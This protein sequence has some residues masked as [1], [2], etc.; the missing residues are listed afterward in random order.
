MESISTFRTWAE[1]TMC[2]FCNQGVQQCEEI[3]CSTCNKIAHQSCTGSNMPIRGHVLWNC[4]ECGPHSMKT[5]TALVLELK[6]CHFPELEEIPAQISALKQEIKML[7]PNHSAVLQREIHKMKKF[8][9]L[10]SASPEVE[11][12]IWED[13]TK[14]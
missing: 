10:R 7:K 3:I 14:I 6:D 11:F 1:Q 8:Y 13:Q 2:L 5:L 4:M 9:Q 12:L